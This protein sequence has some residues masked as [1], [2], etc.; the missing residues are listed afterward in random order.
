MSNPADSLKRR[1]VELGFQ[2]SGVA[3]A[4]TPEGMH[5]LVDWLDKG[6]AG[7]M[8]Y[9]AERQNAYA[10]PNLVLDGVRS[11]L[12]LGM[13]YSG[14]ESIPETS[15]GQGRIA[16]YANGTVDY[17]DLIHSRLKSLHVFHDDL[18]PAESSRGIVDTAPLLE[19]EFA[20]LS[21]IGWIG[22]NTML[23]SKEQGSYF[24][25]AALLSTADLQA[26]NPQTTDH[27]GTCT[28]CLDAC[29]TDAFP[30]PFVLNANRCISY[31]TIEHRDEISGDLR[32]GMG[33]W[34]FGCDICQEVCP[35]NR[36]GDYCEEP[37]LQSSHELANLELYQLFN[38]DDDA[39]RNRFRKTPLWRPKRRGILRNAA[40]VL[41]N[42]AHLESIPA[43][44]KGLSDIEPLVRSACAWAIGKI[45][46]PDSILILETALGV[47]SNETVLKELQ[48]SIH[49]L[50]KQTA[51]SND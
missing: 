38:L 14:Y 35:W 43:L 4:V 41:G 32:T 7:Q 37:D 29:P 3:P 12:M 2:F 47:E 23:I 49:E 16:R 25:L 9:I 40:I 8:S 28:A 33:D 21:G 30:E 46:S 50:L 51:D 27:C 36:H 11:V 22:K 39:F 42:Q 48:K 19:R 5:R 1:A 31:L 13:H 26:D 34:L 6:Y 10:D 15:P 45:N 17:H 18:L 44:R 20:Q 24:F